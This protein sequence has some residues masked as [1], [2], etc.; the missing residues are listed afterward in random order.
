MFTVYRAATGGMVCHCYN[1]LEIGYLG[2]APKFLVHRKS[3]LNLC[4]FHPCYIHT[5]SANNLYRGSFDVD[6]RL[7]SRRR[8]SF[9]MNS[10]LT[11]SAR[12]GTKLCDEKKPKSGALETET[13]LKNLRSHEKGVNIF[14]RSLLKRCYEIRFNSDFCKCCNLLFLQMKLHSALLQRYIQWRNKLYSTAP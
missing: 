3:N 1:S 10:P 11:V 13:T 8:A 7:K 14:S 2:R 4:E 5:A 6:H 9:W 12:F